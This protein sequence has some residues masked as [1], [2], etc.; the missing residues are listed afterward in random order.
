[1]A[2]MD[3]FK[4]S[5]EAIKNAS[6]K[7]KISYFFYYYKWH[8]IITLLV[9]IA[10]VSFIYGQV[11]RKDLSFH[12]V[13]LSAWEN[14]SEAPTFIYDFYDF[15]GIDSSKSEIYLDTSILI[16]KDNPALIEENNASSQKLMVLTAAQDLDMMLATK[17]AFL[18]YAYD[19]VF[20]DLREILT[21]EQFAR[22][23]PYF[24]YADG[25]VIEEIAAAREEMDVSYEPEF[26]DP[27]EPENMTDPIPVGICVDISAL[28]GAY[29]FKEDQLVFGFY[30]NSKRLDTA[31]QFA[32][33]L[34]Q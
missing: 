13:L 16:D 25:K 14:P 30:A 19:D 34:T 3:E 8:V 26:K 33:Y 29:E 24:Y 12:A 7:E 15:A 18:R 4:E 1:M 27:F 5:R 2:V 21:K 11:T 6:L 31:L 23:E 9:I 22:Y 10:L 20:Y 28:K 17:T 32:D